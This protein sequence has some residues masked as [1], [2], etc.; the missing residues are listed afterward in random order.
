ML[1]REASKEPGGYKDRYLLQICDIK[2][3]SYAAYW[4]APL[5]LLIVDATRE[6][7]QIRGETR[8]T[9]AELTQQQS[10]KELAAKQPTCSEKETQL[11]LE[12]VNAI[13]LNNYFYL[14][15]SD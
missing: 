7:V 10:Q 4:A 8:D 5:D 1:F 14:L 11:K 12:R 13:E 2:W 3:I 6:C 9:A 15:L